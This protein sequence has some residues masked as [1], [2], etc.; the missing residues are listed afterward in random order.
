MLIRSVIHVPTLFHLIKNTPSDP[1]HRRLVS[2]QVDYGS[3]EEGDEG[4]GEEEGGN[5]GKDEDDEVDEAEE[6]GSGTQEESHQ[7]TATHRKSKRSQ[8]KEEELQEQDEM[9]VKTVLQSNTAVEGYRY[10]VE[11]ELWCEVSALL[12]D[13]QPRSSL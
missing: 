10:D 2:P 1:T 7:L 5:D 9:R 12:L 3:G 6:K 13:G 4:E 8:G 11:H